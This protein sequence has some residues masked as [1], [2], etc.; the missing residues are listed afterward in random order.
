MFIA[1]AE[2]GWREAGSGRR[3]REGW[4]GDAFKKTGRQPAEGASK[5]TGRCTRQQI[6]KRLRYKTNDRHEKNN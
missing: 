2:L 5:Q 6:N 4:E 1:L 3:V